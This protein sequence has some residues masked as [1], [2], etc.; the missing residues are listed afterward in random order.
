MPLTLFQ[1]LYHY[2]DRELRDFAQFMGMHVRDGIAT[3]SLRGEVED[4]LRK[5][6]IVERV[7][8][9]LDNIDKQYIAEILHWSRMFDMDAFEMRYGGTPSIYRGWINGQ[10]PFGP[11]R[12]L[13]E[14]NEVYRE[15]RPSLLKFVPAPPTVAV[16]VLAAPIGR[17]VRCTE[18]DALHDVLA[19]L[20]L[21]DAGKVPVTEKTGAVGN[22]AIREIEKVLRG[23]GTTIRATSWAT[24]LESSNYCYASEG[25]LALNELG[26][27]A[28]LGAAPDALHHMWRKWMT[29]HRRD[30]LRRINMRD[31]YLTDTIDCRRRRAR[32]KEA[33]QQCPVGKWI[34]LDDFNKFIRHGGF[35]FSL[36]WGEKAIPLLERYVSLFLSEFA[37]SAGIVDLTYDDFLCSFRITPLG[38]WL[39]GMQDDYGAPSAV[40]GGKLTALSSLLLIFDAEPSPEQAVFLDR[41]CERET[42]TIWK[43][44]KQRTLSALERGFTTNMLREFIQT[45]DDQPLPETMQTWLERIE[46]ELVSA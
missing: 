45:H 13:A 17:N 42:A 32:I 7:Y 10:R 36:C 8:E 35:Y 34:A 23:D 31:V 20:N 43:L 15:V 12:L 1:A 3:H 27:S 40:S 28:S 18:S 46:K 4:A 2:T 25:K 21:V 9:Q 5:R 26:L 11:L 14:R 6:E 30:E 41:F 24:M 33:L 39:L 44:S 38:A 22:A 29:Q 37:A 19:V 16:N